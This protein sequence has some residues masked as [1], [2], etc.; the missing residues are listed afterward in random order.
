VRPAKVVGGL[1]RRRPTGSQ[2]T[3]DVVLAPGPAETFGLAALEA[4]AC[5]TPVVAGALSA[6]PALIGPA[7]AAATDDGPAFATAVRYVLAR[8]EHLRRAVAG[9]QAERY[10]GGTAV[11]AFLAAHDTVPRPA[12]REAGP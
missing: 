2:A 8:P 5:G 9:A 11:G 3:A 4:L 7:G 12:L 10:T 6:L 1:A